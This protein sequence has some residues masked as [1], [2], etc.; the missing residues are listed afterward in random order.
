MSNSVKLSDLKNPINFLALGLGSG[1]SPKAPGTAGSLLAVCLYMLFLQQLPLWA[2]L[3]IILVAAFAGIAICGYT[4]KQLGVD[5][6]PAIVWDEFAGQWIA[7]ICVV[8]WVSALGAF[9]L[10]RIFD[11][12][13]PGPI[14][15]LDK[16]LHS[17][18]GIMADDLLAGIA[19]LLSLQ[20]LIMMFA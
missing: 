18:L 11:I 20:F 8:D 7:L 6:H 16:K 10:F 19:A 1:L 13:K 4:A 12:A 14:G 15:W 5:D 17:G 9:V 2:F 3:G